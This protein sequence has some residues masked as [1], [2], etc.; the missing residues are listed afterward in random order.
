[1]V[2]KNTEVLSIIVG[3]VLLAAFVY[4]LYKHVKRKTV[5]RSAILRLEKELKKK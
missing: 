1:L 5:K 3:V 4:F 2:R